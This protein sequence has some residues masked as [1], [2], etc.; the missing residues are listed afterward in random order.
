MTFLN[1]AK[2]NITSNI[3]LFIFK[4]KQFPSDRQPSALLL[5]KQLPRP[6]LKIVIEC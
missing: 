4:S 1:N 3:L 2:T 6:S 5:K